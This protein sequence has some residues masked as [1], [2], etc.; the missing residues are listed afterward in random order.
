MWGADR[1]SLF[2]VD[3]AA[4][5]N[6]SPTLLRT[7]SPFRLILCLED[8]SDWQLARTH[9]IV[10]RVDPR[11]SRTVLVATK[12]VSHYTITLPLRPVATVISVR[13]LSGDAG[14]EDRTILDAR[15]PSPSAQPTAALRNLQ[16]ATCGAYLHLDPAG[17]HE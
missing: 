17:T 10:Q 7:A 6:L 15:R 11:L 14:R 3:V 4:I 12:L 8:T 13:G 2:L 16:G 9:P 1:S 5:S